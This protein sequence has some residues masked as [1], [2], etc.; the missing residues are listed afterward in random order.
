MSMR[1]VMPTTTDRTRMSRV[2]RRRRRRRPRRTPAV[3][4]AVVSAV[5]TG[6][7]TTTP[8]LGNGLGEDALCLIL[9]A[10]AQSVNVALAVLVDEALERL[11][12][13]GLREVRPS[14]PVQV[15][16]D[17]LG[18]GGERRRVLLQLLVP[19]GGR[20]RVHRDVA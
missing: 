3:R 7:A 17:V 2:S 9:H 16:R 10:A 14:V 12:D 15:L 20:V 8:T 6:V 19:V 1:T 13:H 4:G 5:G 11:D 18:L